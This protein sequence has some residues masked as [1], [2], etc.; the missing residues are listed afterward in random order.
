M[1]VTGGIAAYKAL[2]LVRLF[3]K[4]GWD[5]AVV[6]TRAARKF[7]GPESFAALTGRPVA[8]ELFPRNR[9]KPAGSGGGSVEHVD[10]AG[11]ADLIVV[12]PATANIIGKLAAGVAD[13]LLS[14]LLLAVPAET[15]DRGRVLFA[16]AMNVNMWQ[17]PTVQSNVRKLMG[18]GYRFLEPARGELACGAC[19]AGRLPEPGVIFERCRAALAETAVPDLAGVRVLVTTGRTEEPLDPVRVITNRSS[20]RMGREV[21]TAFARAG[22]DVTLIAGPVSVPLPQDVRA[23]SVSTTEEMR[24]AVLQRLGDTDILVMCAAVSDYRPARAARTKRSA[25]SLVLELERTPDILTDVSK[26]KHSALVVG[27]SLD[28][29]LDRARAK[30]ERKRLDLIVANP[31]DTPGS[32]FIK[33]RLLFASGRSSALPAMPKAEF[34]R[35]L[36]G[37]VAGLHRRKKAV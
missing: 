22:A 31:T 20:G 36:V 28:D 3:R 14:T 18:Y 32:D 30:I 4:A 25:R 12:A 24:E 6:M 15:R 19:G 16:P 27:F 7:V 37:V 5:V 35:R 13:D 34:A 11:W 26:R 33:P 21:A 23:V 29:A 1:G 17:S 9:L 8:L 10:L 2:E